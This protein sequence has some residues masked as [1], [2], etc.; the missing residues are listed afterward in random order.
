MC[1]SIAVEEKLLG[2]RFGRV[3]VVIWRR[4]LK[5]ILRLAHMHVAIHAFHLQN[6]LTLLSV[7]AL[8]AIALRFV[9]T[10]NNL[11]T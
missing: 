1:E 4:I 3:S 6:A 9:L 8:S 10:Q 7:T 5:N 11:S 2:D